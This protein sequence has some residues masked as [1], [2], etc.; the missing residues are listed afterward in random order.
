MMLNYDVLN[1]RS[2]AVGFTDRLCS[3][4]EQAGISTMGQLRTRK[5]VELEK[6]AG[7]SVVSLNAIR[8]KLIEMYDTDDPIL[9]SINIRLE[10]IEKMLE[11]LV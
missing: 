5:R 1:I 6:I 8:D 2:K 7:V 10:R 4:L 9:C 11:K 3:A